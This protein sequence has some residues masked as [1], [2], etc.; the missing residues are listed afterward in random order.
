MILG[1]RPAKLPAQ[2]IISLSDLRQE[3]VLLCMMPELPGDCFLYSI[4]VADT[5]TI[6]TALH[7]M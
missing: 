6:P 4:M 5:L 1:S 7:N 2:H 3:Q